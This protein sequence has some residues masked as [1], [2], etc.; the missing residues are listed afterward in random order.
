MKQKKHRKKGRF[1]L[2]RA[3]SFARDGSRV[4]GS[5]CRGRGG[6]WSSRR[7]RECHWE[8]SIFEGIINAT[9]RR[10]YLVRQSLPSASSV[11]ACEDDGLRE[12]SRMSVR[13]AH[14]CV[15]VCLPCVCPPSLVCTDRSKNTR[16]VS[17]ATSSRPSMDH[18]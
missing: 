8:S 14:A 9:W 7:F 6:A 18:H 17:W 15:D 13:H 1:E 4:C 16:L 5:L 11:A 3:I 2:S 12:W 10:P